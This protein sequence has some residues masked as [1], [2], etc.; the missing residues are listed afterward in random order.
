[1]YTMLAILGK[2]IHKM[3][4]CGLQGKEGQLKLNLKQRNIAMTN[5][6]QSSITINEYNE[7]TL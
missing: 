5:Q 6:W 3:F 4:V 2:S 1:M 7:T